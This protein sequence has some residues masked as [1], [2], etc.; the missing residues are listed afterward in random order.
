MW[1]YDAVETFKSH[2][3]YQQ[4]TD[5]DCGLHSEVEVRAVPELTR[6]H[7]NVVN[8]VQISAES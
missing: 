5:I 3:E 4:V 8:S 6:R 1:H 7:V 2:A